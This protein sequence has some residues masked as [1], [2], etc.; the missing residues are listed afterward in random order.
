MYLPEKRYRIQKSQNT[1]FFVDKT[2]L[3]GSIAP[4]RATSLQHLAT[5]WTSSRN[6]ISTVTTFEKAKNVQF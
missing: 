6:D 3:D 2:S 5:L 4:F 1:D